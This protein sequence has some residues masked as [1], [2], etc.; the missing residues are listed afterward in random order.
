[1]RDAGGVEDEEE[2]REHRHALRAVEETA[3]GRRGRQ[4]VG[5]DAHDTRNTLR[6]NDVGELDLLRELVLEVS[7]DGERNRGNDEREEGVDATERK[8]GVVHVVAVNGSGVADGGVQVVR[9]EVEEQRLV[10]RVA[11]VPASQQSSAMR[12]KERVGG[13]QRV[14]RAAVVQGDVAHEALHV[15][16]RRDSH[17]KPFTAHAHTTA[18]HHV[19][20]HHRHLLGKPFLAVDGER[21]ETPACGP[22]L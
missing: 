11:R 15:S 20:L 17:H 8:E 21:Y 4:Q 3:V 22:R 18:R 12:R 13:H 6:G 10:H 16:A 1:M 2:T 7:E 19:T 14:C 5:D 9:G